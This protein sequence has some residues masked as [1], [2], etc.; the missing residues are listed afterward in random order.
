[1]LAIACA[2][3]ANLR[4]AQATTRIHELSVRL[5]LGATRGRLMGILALESALLTAASALVAWFITRLVLV[6][7]AGLF[8]MSLARST[9]RRCARVKSASA[10]PSAPGRRTSFA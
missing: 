1:V 8:P 2:N 5:S 7:V 6:Q 3:V 9:R 10:S 4:L